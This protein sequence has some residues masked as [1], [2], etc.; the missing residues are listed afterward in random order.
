[1]VAQFGPRPLLVESDI[2]L[3]SI[4]AHKAAAGII[5]RRDSTVAV[6]VRSVS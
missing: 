1:L 4:G 2:E 6:A 3:H 5:E